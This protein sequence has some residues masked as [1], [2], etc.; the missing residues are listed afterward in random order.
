MFASEFDVNWEFVSTPSKLGVVQV[1]GVLP[2]EVAGGYFQKRSIA[3]PEDA[4]LVRFKN[5]SLFATFNM[6]NAAL[7]WR[8]MHLFSF[9]SGRT[10]PLLL[11]FGSDLAEKL[12]YF[13]LVKDSEK[14]WS[15]LVLENSKLAT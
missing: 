6:R 10:K 9:D 4:R 12:R 11:N 3:G 7:D 14:N 8:L 5:G 2:I 15:P 1:P 13:F